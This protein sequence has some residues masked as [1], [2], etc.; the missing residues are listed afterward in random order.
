MIMRPTVCILAGF[1]VWIFSS[2]EAFAYVDPG[3]GTFVLQILAAAAVGT[4][5]Y[6][7]RIVDRAKKFFLPGREDK[8]RSKDVTD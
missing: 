1:L 8:R 5:F 7:R 4:L 3:T 2:S 6:I